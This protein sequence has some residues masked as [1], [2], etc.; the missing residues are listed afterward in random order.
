MI[1]RGA[2]VCAQD[3]I[4][5]TALHSAASKNGREAM[6]QLL[7]DEGVDVN[8]R[9]YEGRTALHEAARRANGGNIRV[10]HPRTA[11]KSRRY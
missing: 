3:Y 5:W 6:L 9:D 1:R 8:T 11:R 7:L 2:K 4:G 10:K